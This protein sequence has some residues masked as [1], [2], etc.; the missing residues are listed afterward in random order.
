MA[1]HKS[2]I[3]ASG[4]TIRRISGEVNRIVEVVG[5][6]S[7]VELEVGEEL[8]GGIGETASAL[9]QTRPEVIG[10]LLPVELGEEAVLIAHV[11]IEPQLRLVAIEQVAEWCV[12]LL[13]KNRD[14]RVS[15]RQSAV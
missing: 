15:K 14:G 12:D 1:L 7:D 6:T 5:R 2:G 3:N 4:L 11:V 9:Y 10:L 13:L 8:L